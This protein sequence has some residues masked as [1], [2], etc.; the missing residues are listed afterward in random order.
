MRV[1]LLNGKDFY[2][3]KMLH[4][5]LMALK[6]LNEDDYDSLILITGPVGAGKSTLGI[7]GLTAIC[8]EFSMNN[9][10]FNG[11]QFE[12]KVIN[13]LPNFDGVQ[14][15]EAVDGMSGREHYKQ[16]NIRLEKLLA[17][18]RLKNMYITA[19]MPRLKDFSEFTIQRAA[20][21]LKCFT[22]KKKRGF[23]VGFGPKRMQAVYY[24]EKN[25]K[26]PKRIHYN[27]RGRFMD[28]LGNIT[29]AEYRQSKSDAFIEY[30]SKN[31]KITSP[32]ERDL[33]LA[34]KWKEKGMSYKKI[35]DL[36]GK[37]PQAVHQMVVKHTNSLEK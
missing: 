9:V 34:L 17:K 5:N 28:G 3:E 14:I 16:I 27:F 36:F 8:P 37:S 11:E 35:G 29:K 2:M 6:K 21:W 1:P 23:F 30:Y 4:E 32:I 25:R 20:L 22:F 15:D 33:Q 18:M 31:K 10:A 7:Q 24:R 26:S 13:V 19:C 12:D